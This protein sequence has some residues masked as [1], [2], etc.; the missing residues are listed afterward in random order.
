MYKFLG[1]GELKILHHPVNGTYR[2]V[3]RREQIHKLVLNQKISKSLHLQPMDNSPKAFVWTGLNFAESTEGEAEQ[4]AARFKN[5]DL[6]NK[7]LEK[8]NE[9]IELSKANENLHPEND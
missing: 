1:V 7:F 6:A 2:F 9:T 8:V 4:L 5:E 3:L